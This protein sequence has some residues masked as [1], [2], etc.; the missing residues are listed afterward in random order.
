MAVCKCQASSAVM[1]TGGK[2][3]NKP[4]LGLIRVAEHS[5]DEF[6]VVDAVLPF[7]QEHPRKTRSRVK[8]IRHLLVDTEAGRTEV[9][10]VGPGEPGV[11]RNAADT[12]DQLTR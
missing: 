6:S 5:H 12:R 2:I 11:H 4:L 3:H 8:N 9:G 7:V 1:V 10:Y